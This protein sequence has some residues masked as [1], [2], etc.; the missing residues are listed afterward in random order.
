MFSVPQESASPAV[1]VLMSGFN[2]ERFLRE[3][4]ESILTQT[5]TNFELLIMDDGSSDSTYQIASSFD[6]PRIR[7]FRNE[8]NRGIVAS[9]NE[10]AGYARAGILA[11]HDADDI[12]E[13]TR[14]ASQ[15]RHMCSHSETVV[16]GAAIE[17]INASGQHIGGWGYPV[18]DQEI[19]LALVERSAFAN[20]VTFIRKDAFDKVGGYRTGLE[21]CEDYDFF[22]RIAEYGRLANLPQ[23]LY[24]LRRHGDNQTIKNAKK[25]LYLHLLVRLSAHSRATT[26][27]DIPLPRHGSDVEALLK[28]RF[29]DDFEQAKPWISDQ[30]LHRAE[31][32]IDCGNYVAACRLFASA[33]WASFSKWRVGWF[34]RKVWMR[35]SSP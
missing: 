22:L 13:P 8:R 30:L 15:Y 28:A 23:T 9:V 11:R 32:A 12:S 3:A 10:L 26:G 18:S 19:R 34:V 7:V 4:I 5:F 1:S 27:T 6:D 14:F 2:A 25:Q 24:R 20:P 33:C 21:P 31:Q 29:R 35:I 16:L 17:L